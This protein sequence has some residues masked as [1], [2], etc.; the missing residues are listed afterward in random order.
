MV[1]F[2]GRGVEA[3]LRALLGVGLLQRECVSNPIKAMVSMKLI[4]VECY[5][6]CY[7]H[8]QTPTLNASA[9]QGSGEPQSESFGITPAKHFWYPAVW[10]MLAAAA[11]ATIGRLAAVRKHSTTRHASHLER[12]SGTATQHG[13]TAVAAAAALPLQVM[14]LP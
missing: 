5:M 13:V 3:L 4:C 10:W 11:V 14:T 12:Q 9:G 8:I 2:G 6:T 1:A 7:K